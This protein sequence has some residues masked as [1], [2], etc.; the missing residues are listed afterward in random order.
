MSASITYLHARRRALHAVERH[1]H[2]RSATAAR[3]PPRM[4]PA[5]PTA[6]APAATPDRFA[7]IP[8]VLGPRWLL[9]LLGYALLCCTSL[10]A[11]AVMLALGSVPA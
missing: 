7:E 10:G 4:L 6:P 5:A 8:R 9:W 2:T 3:I 1:A 11:C